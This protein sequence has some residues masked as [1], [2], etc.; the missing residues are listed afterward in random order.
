MNRIWITGF[1]SYDLG[2]FNNKD[3]KLA[4]INFALNKLL[5]NAIYDNCNWLI[6]G[7]QL[8]IEQWAI[9]EAL[10]LKQTNFPDFQIALMTPFLDFGKNWQ[11]GKRDKLT[12]L[13]QAVD[14]SSSV[15]ASNYESPK[16]L[17]AYQ[18]FM[19][20]HTDRAIIFYDQEAES[21]RARFD[22]Q[23]MKNY[24]SNHNY[25]VMLIDLDRLQDYADEY[26]LEKSD[27]LE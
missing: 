23:A 18:E 2:I 7:G 6:T 20:N 8:G 24:A 4:I 1:R 27:Y 9:E 16:Q 25:P 5:T 10:R 3:P 12:S 11:E 14:F 13:K 26:Q 21:S 19:L 22:Y 15:F 17:Q